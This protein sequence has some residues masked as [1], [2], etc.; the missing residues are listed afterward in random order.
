MKQLGC[1][2]M[3]YRNFSLEQALAGIRQA[4]G[5][6]IELCARSSTTGQIAHLDLNRHDDVDGHY[7]EVKQA[8][9]AH[10]LKV[11]SIA[12]SGQQISQP[13]GLKRLIEASCQL[14]TD[15]VVVNSGGV[16]NSEESFLQFVDKVNQASVALAKG[17]IRLSIKPQMGRAVHDVATAKQLM[18]EVDADWVGLNFDAT[19]IY[20]SHPD[21]D[22]VQALTELQPHIFTVRMR[23]HRLSREP[24]VGAVGTQIPGNGVLDLAGLTSIIKQM[25]NISVAILEIVGIHKLPNLNFDTVQEIVTTS[26]SYLKP[27]LWEYVATPMTTI[28]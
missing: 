3:L 26:I 9:T 7:Q 12:I 8:I 20:R 5:Y 18:T 11:E 1:S 17:Q 19:H 21:A 23:D 2:T 27:L 22:P 14:K 4:G 13:A 6:A 28:I 25:P 10:G 24:K 16:S 15:T